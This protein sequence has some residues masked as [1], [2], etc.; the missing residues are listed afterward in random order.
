MR[1][2]QL[3]MAIGYAMRTER[4]I[5]RKTLQEVADHL[6]ISKSQVSLYETG[7]TPI[8][9]ELLNDYCEYLGISMIDLLNEIDTHS[10]SFIE[11]NN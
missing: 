9:C 8:T 3:R 11:E 5:R 6:H 2:I 4:L 7:K 1:G 10:D